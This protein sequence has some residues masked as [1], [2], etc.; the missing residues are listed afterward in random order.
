[1]RETLSSRALCSLMDVKRWMPGFDLQDDELDDEFTILINSESQTILR[2]TRREFVQPADNPTF[3]V[4]DVTEDVVAERLLEIGDIANTD[5]IQVLLK[6][7]TGTTLQTVPG[8]SVTPRPLS[9]ELS[10]WE[11][12]TMLELPLA[13]TE[14]ALLAAGQLA[15]VQA[16][17]GFP[18]IPDDIRLI[19]SA[20][21]VGRAMMDVARIGKALSGLVNED[22][23][24]S[25]LRTGERV[26][27]GYRVPVC[28]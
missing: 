3:R 21:V 15:S 23:L 9:G 17:W 13:V 8:A 27:T 25:T 7:R 10:E 1:M 28:A 11:P 16:N 5:D 12:I 4:F 20:R 24:R 2:R 6:D 22:D 19:T 18:A 14:P 26:I